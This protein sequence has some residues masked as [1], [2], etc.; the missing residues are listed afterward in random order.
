M[1]KNDQDILAEYYQYELSY[2]RSAGSDFAARF[3]KIA[4]RLDLSHN[5]SSDPHVER[6]IESFAFLTGKLQKQID[7]QFPEIA[8][9]LLDVLYQPLTLPIPSCVM[10]NFDVDVAKVAKAPG[11]IIP[12]HTQLQ[13]FC[14]SGEICS[15]RTAHDLP[16]WP[17]K[18]TS[19]SMVQKEHL[20]GYYARSVYYIKLGI[21]GEPAQQTPR[22]L[23]FYIQAN[24][25]L[26]GKIFSA[27]FST[28]ENVLHQKNDDFEFCR[29]IGP[30]GVEE[31]DALFT[32]PPTIHSGFRLLQE[33]FSFPDKFYGF[34][35]TLPPGKDLF[36]ENFLYIPMN[37]D[38]SMQISADNF[39]LFSTPAIN[40]FPKVTEP[41]RLDHKQVEY[42]LAPDYRRHSSH[43]IYSIEKMVAIDAKNNDEIHIPEFF[44]CDHYSV[45]SSGIFWKSR[46]K[47]TYARDIPGE[48]VYVSFIDI[49]FN[50]QNPADKIFYAHTLCTNRYMAEQIPVCGALQMELSAP[51]KRIYCADRPTVQKP[52]IKKGEVLWKLISALSLNS[53]SFDKGGINKI[54][55][56]LEVFADASGSPLGVEVDSIVSLDCSVATGRVD[57]QTWRGFVRGSNVEITFDDAISNLG[58][59]LSLVLSRFLSSYTSINT[60]TDVS[61]K[62]I[63]TN[64]ILKRWEQQFGAKNYL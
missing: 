19:A 29:P 58:L 38:I 46:R 64:G 21:N 22:K 61:V 55:E 13:A 23:R 53:I 16:L 63:S 5:E 44:S 24:A 12:R 28:D 51:V 3:P 1:T 37:Y 15:L 41:L 20:P 56:L 54:R 48:D 10:V 62:N 27:I 39:S 14:H 49:N 36:G 59:P 40:L 31:E 4:R 26:R 8:A 33:Y 42:Q 47:K 7:D 17:I 25:L 9:T 45:N 43:E 18:I 50:P 30:V 2:L 32:Y 35:V 52:S 57:E 11:F 6:M 34:D 60:F